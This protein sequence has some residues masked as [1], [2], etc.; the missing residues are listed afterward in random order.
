ML[1]L[2]LINTTFIFVKKYQ[3][4][5]IQLYSDLLLLKIFTNKIQN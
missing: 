3:C 4:H 2:M 5:I 1:M